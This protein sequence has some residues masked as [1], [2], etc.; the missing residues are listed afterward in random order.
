MTKQLERAAA[1]AKQ[2][3]CGVKLLMGCTYLVVTPQ[4]HR[5]TVRFHMHDGQRY[6]IC[7]CKAGAANM[8]CYHLI[9]AAL[10][11]NAVQNVRGR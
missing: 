1:K 8:M 9:P 11:D 7:N 5:Y 2:H 10:T 6:G 3:K 4:G